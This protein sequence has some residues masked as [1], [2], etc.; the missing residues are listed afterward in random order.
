MSRR[1]TPAEDRFCGCGIWELPRSVMAFPLKTRPAEGAQERG[2][3]VSLNCP[4]CGQG[5]CFFNANDPTHL[6][7]A[8]EL[9]S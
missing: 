6:A 1:K 3:Y 4:E 5:H 2:A 9:L 7:A 8:R